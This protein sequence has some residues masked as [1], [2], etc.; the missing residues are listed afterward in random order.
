MSASNLV[1]LG[2]D[3]SKASFDVALLKSDKRSKV[4][5]FDNTSEGFEQLS[6]WLRGQGVE[7]V[8]ACLEATNVYGHALA[9]HLFRQGHQVSIVNPARVKGY[10]KSQLSRT[11]ND[12]ADAGLIARFC[13]DLKPSLW[14]PCAAEVAKLQGFSRRLEALEHMVTQEQNRLDICDEEFRADIE[15]HIQFLKGQVESVKKRLH[16]HIKAH[17]SLAKQH[18]LLTSIAGIGDKTAAIVLAEIGTLAV[19]GSARQLAAFAGLTPQEFTSG[20]SV[21]GKTRLCKIGNPRLRKA[22]YFPALTSIRH[23]PQIQAFRQRLLQAGKTKMQVVG[24]VMHKLIRVIY[25]VL[26]SGQPFDASKLMPPNQAQSKAEK[27]LTSA[28]AS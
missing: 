1:A 25:G 16:E 15:A 2:I 17:E 22:L 27:S 14:H 21:N 19:F 6:Q 11:K 23:C 9:I 4:G 28:L 20:S 24:A 12:R 7:Q 26:K 18:Q 8:H 13:R 10:A 3:I 5:K